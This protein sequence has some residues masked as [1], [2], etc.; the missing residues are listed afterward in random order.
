MK[1]SISHRNR[2]TQSALAC[3][4]RQTVGLVL[5]SGMLASGCSRTPQQAQP[6]DGQAAPLRQ[7]RIAA[8]ASI[9]PALDEII[10]SFQKHHDNVR[11]EVSYGS[12]GSHVAQ[13]NN[14]APFDMFLAADMSYPQQLVDDGLAAEAAVFQ[15]AVG[16]LVLW[17]STRS[18]P[19]DE[20]HQLNAL[21]DPRVRRIAIANPQHAP[22]GRAAVAAMQHCGIYEQVR[23][24]LVLGESIA[25][26][27]QLV[28]SG[29]ADAGI[30]ALSLIFVSPLR[31]T[32]WHQEIAP[33]AYPPIEHGGVILSKARNAELAIAFRDF[34]LSDEGQ[35]ILRAYRLAMRN[36]EAV[37]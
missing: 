3:W 18:A 13:L 35:N 1:R 12:S 16:R 28:E 36:S 24:R 19:N 14:G 20:A 2:E 25:H 8:A 21:L 5:L 33:E 29:A 27:A 7:L 26:T 23:N 9:R 30:I 11:V 37:D 31:A 22:Y 6:V 32:G 4:L 10:R 34:L 17:L 15:Y